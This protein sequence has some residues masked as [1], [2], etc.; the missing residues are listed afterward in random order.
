M[1]SL[2]LG[3]FLVGFPRWQPGERGGLPRWPGIELG[4]QA[5]AVGLKSLSSFFMCVLF[6]VNCTVV[7]SFEPRNQRYW[8][9]FF[10]ASVGQLLLWCL[11]WK[12]TSDRALK[13][14]D[15]RIRMV[16][17]MSDI[18]S[19]VNHRIQ[20]VHWLAGNIDPFCKI[21]PV[22]LLMCLQLYFAGC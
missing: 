16:C 1:I 5:Q 21:D 4:G 20:S 15:W 11:K 8:M 17:I 7:F 12:M 10:V 3:N 18:G 19:P 14:G 2:R 13:S 6:E 9:L 22:D